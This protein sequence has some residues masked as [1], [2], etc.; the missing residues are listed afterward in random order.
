MICI[1]IV[2]DLLIA[3]SFQTSLKLFSFMSQGIK[4][5]KIDGETKRVNK[6]S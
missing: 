1:F 5:N 3:M 4:G 2:N 6:H